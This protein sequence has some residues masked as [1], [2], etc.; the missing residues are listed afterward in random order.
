MSHT[1]AVFTDSPHVKIFN[2][3]VIKIE[4]RTYSTHYFIVNN[5]K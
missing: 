4:Y 3:Y 5:T 2:M 1:T